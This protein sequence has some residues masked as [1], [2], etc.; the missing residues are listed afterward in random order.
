MSLYLTTLGAVPHAARTD[1]TGGGRAPHV[2][3]NIQSI[4]LYNSSSWGLTHTNF[5]ADVGLLYTFTK[6]LA[7]NWAKMG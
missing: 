4:A 1:G 2:V 3:I 5:T 7:A 6:T